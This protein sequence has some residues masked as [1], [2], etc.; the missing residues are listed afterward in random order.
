MGQNQQ[1]S[2]PE[3]KKAVEISQTTFSGKADKVETGTGQFRQRDI[4][5]FF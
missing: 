2:F 1:V 5:N 4:L 3:L